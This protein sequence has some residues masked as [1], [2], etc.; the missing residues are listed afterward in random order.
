MFYC[1]TS[2]FSYNDWSGIYY[3]E[4]LPRKNWF[5]YYAQEFNAVE[6]NFTYYALPDIATIK[7]LAARTGEGFLFA[8]KAHQ[9]MTHKRQLDAGIF[10]AFRRSLE[11]LVEQGKLG[12]VLAQFPYSFGPASANFEY[13]KNFHDWMQ[14]LAMV[15]EFRNAGWLN[16]KILDWMKAQNIGFCCVDEPPLSRLLPPIAE[17]TSDIGYVRFHGRN[18]AKWWNHE[19]AWERYDYTYKREELE[20]WMPRINQISKVAEKT[21]IFANNHWRSQAVDTIRQVR[22]MLDQLVL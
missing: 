17:V 16:Q 11:P 22:S 21:F 10:E 5:S 1:G 18:E 9:E 2:G 7:S 13:L 20:E 3:P 12:C 14:G 6:L 4:R 15:I 8:V 19:H